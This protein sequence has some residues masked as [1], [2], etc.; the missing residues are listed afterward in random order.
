MIRAG[1]T[2]KNMC[3]E[4]SLG[5]SPITC[6]GHSWGQETLIDG[7]YTE[8]TVSDFAHVLRKSR[9]A[10]SQPDGGSGNVGRILIRMNNDRR[11]VYPVYI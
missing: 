8:W 7:R 5:A 9:F 1:D 10:R 6:F 11:N 2:I 4:V 3:R